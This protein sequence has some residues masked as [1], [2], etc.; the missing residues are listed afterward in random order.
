MEV[1]TQIHVHFI[2]RKLVIA[3][4]LNYKNGQYI[5]TSLIVV[6]QSVLIDS[7]STFRLFNTTYQPQKILT[8]LQIGQ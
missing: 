5:V 6:H 3:C 7:M 2:V 1:F 4:R 8:E